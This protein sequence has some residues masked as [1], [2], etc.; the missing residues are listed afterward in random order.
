MLNQQ[1]LTLILRNRTM[2]LFGM[3]NVWWGYLFCFLFKSLMS[4]QRLLPQAHRQN[5]LTEHIIAHCLPYFWVVVVYELNNICNAFQIISM[6]YIPVAAHIHASSKA[7]TKSHLQRYKHTTDMPHTCHR[8]NRSF[9]IIHKY[10][11]Y[12]LLAR[13]ISA[14]NASQTLSLYISR[15]TQHDEEVQQ[16]SIV[17]NSL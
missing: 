1:L 11:T 12:S 16:Q 10:I 13:H 2:K 8:W 7:C 17:L 14:T 4:N 3:H 5:N 6:Y 15:R 9:A